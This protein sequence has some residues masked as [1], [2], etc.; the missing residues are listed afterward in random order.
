[1]PSPEQL[2]QRS[3]EATA[4]GVAGAA[5]CRSSGPV[6]PGVP[7][8]QDQAEAGR[9]AP[10]LEPPS[11]H[12]PRINAKWPA[13]TPGRQ[14]YAEP[15][16]EALPF[17]FAHPADLGT[18][19]VPVPAAPKAPILDEIASTA[20]HPLELSASRETATRSPAGQD[21][22]MPPPRY[23]PR[24]WQGRP[25][26][27]LDLMRQPFHYPT[28]QCDLKKGRGQHRMGCEAQVRLTTARFMRA[29]AACWAWVTACLKHF[30]APPV[31]IEYA[32]R[33]AR[34]VGNCC[35][36]WKAMK[37]KGCQNVFNYH[38]VQGCNSRTCP[39]C[40]R[41]WA[42]KA[43]AA[44]F[45]YV[46]EYEVKREKGVVS[47]DYFM[48]TFTE[49]KPDDLS[50][51]GLRTSIYN[52]KR[53]AKNVW[54]KVVQYLPRRDGFTDGDEYASTRARLAAEMDATKGLPRE[55][56]E[57]RRAEIRA[58]RRDAWT[59][60]C[61]KY[62]GKCKEA[63]MVA[64]VDLGVLG[65]VHLHAL[66]YGAEHRSDD[67]RAA[68]G[69]TWTKDIAV[70]PKRCNGH[71]QSPDDATAHAVCETLKYVC[72]TSTNPGTRGFVHPMLAV[73][74]ELASKDAKLRQGYG[75]M[76]GMIADLNRREDEGE[77]DEEPGL[78]ACPKCGCCEDD[79]ERVE[80]HYQEPTLPNDGWCLRPDA[81]PSAPPGGT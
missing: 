10:P 46:E 74:F 5:T 6:P 45:V 56:R 25:E 33:R 13:T 9:P 76:R 81:S 22:P 75:S 24:P 54:E 78:D 48:H 3:I 8:T 57:I 11:P 14:L 69:G 71:M 62:P 12:D 72:K 19:G 67:I 16:Q 44:A 4:T 20:P 77:D 31:L 21:V 32:A 36:Y 38:Q 49:Q 79:L 35:T 51:K 26:P 30:D 68:A 39:V 40:G 23:L 28:C 18:T 41:R 58:A 2:R 70:R 1:M 63:G 53:K 65:N 66:R 7:G 34:V 55:E 59:Q 52:V 29:L 43:W 17:G 15:A 60:H 61:R 42:R 64:Q 80:F 73:L 47:R 27:L 50:L 37:C